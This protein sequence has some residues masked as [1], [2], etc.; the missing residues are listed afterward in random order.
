M[1]TNKKNISLNHTGNMSTVQFHWA[2]K[3]FKT[4]S[5]LISE[6][7][8]TVPL[9]WARERNGALGHVARLEKGWMLLEKMQIEIEV[10]LYS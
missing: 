6:E 4:V 5:V 9:M 7:E 2:A 10:L 3:S 1:K 8:V